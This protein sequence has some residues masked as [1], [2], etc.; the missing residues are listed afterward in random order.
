MNV[1]PS[2]DNFFFLEFT[3]FA[4]L[5]LAFG[6]F[7]SALIHRVPSGQSVLSSKDRSACPHCGQVLKARDLIPLFSW[8]LSKGRC[9]YCGAKLSM[10]YPLLE[11]TACILTLAV[12][13]LYKG[14]SL[15]EQVVV[16]FSIPILLALFVI[17]LQHKILPNVLVLLLAVLGVIRLVTIFIADMDIGKLMAFESGL[18]ALVFGLVAWLMAFLMEKALKKPAM[19][20]GDVKFFAVA[21]LWLG[22]SDLAAFCIFSGILGVI[23]GLIWRK[24]HKD[25][26]FPFGPALIAAFFTLLLIDSSLFL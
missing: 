18:G 11:V 13:L 9:R 14:T 19:G 7:A 12:L 1:L 17:D 6:S 3:A 23:L 24:I 10:M 4:V 8:L 22:I 26:A 25:E 20:M 2:F 5:G 15:A 21:G 16:A